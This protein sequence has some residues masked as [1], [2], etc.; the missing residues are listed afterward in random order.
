MRQELGEDA[1]LRGGPE[2]SV[3]GAV[4]VFRCNPAKREGKVLD[5]LAY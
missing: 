4:A 3:P 1:A 5:G 2:M